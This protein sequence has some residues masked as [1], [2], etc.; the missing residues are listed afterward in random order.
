MSFP[1]SSDFGCTFVV[2]LF[3]IRNLNKDFSLN[4][5]IIR[6]LRQLLGSRIAHFSHEKK[7]IN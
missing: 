3:L 4:L 5:K 6:I 1:T 2:G 7:L